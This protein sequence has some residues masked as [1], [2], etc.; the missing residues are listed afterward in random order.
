MIAIINRLDQWHQSAILAIS[1]LGKTKLIV[2]ESVL[3]ETLNYFAEFRP[4]AKQHAAETI[5]SFSANVNVEV[6]EQTSEMFHKGIKLYK[7]RL[8]KEYSLTDCIL[9]N[10]CRELA[11]AEILT[12]DHHF[13][14]EG[15]RILL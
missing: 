12:H 7:S 10:V 1:K 13:E 9:M 3:V 4:E 5:E 2:T 6:I 15:F 8:D 14:Q 11:I